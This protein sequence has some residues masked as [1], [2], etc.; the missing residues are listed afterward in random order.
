M[1]DADRPITSSSQDRLGRA[2]FA[3]Y[4]ARC[5]LDHK[6]P[7]SMVVGL[8]GGW[9]SGKTSVINLIVEELKRAASAM[10]EEDQPI[11]LNFSP[12]SYSGQHQLI[13]S[14]FRRLSAVIR[15]SSNLKNKERIITLLELYVSYFSEKPLP[16]IMLPKRHWWQHKQPKPITGWES[17][18]DL[19]Q[20]KAELNHLLG[21]E[22]CRIVIIIDNITRLYDDEIKLMFQIV[23][24]MGDYANTTY[25]LALDKDYVITAINNVDG[26]GGEELLEKVVQLPFTITPI[27]QQDVEPILADRLKNVVLQVPEDTWNNEYWADLYYSSL[28]YFFKNCRDIT[29]YV[30]TLNFSY[31]RVKDIVNPVDYF[32][33]TAIEI[34]LPEIYAGIR[35]NKDLFTDL[36]DDVYPLTKT[37]MPVEKLRVHEILNREPAIP[38]D[39]ILALLLKL[40]PRLRHICQPN[41]K[42]Y[43]STAI[44]R[45]LK[46]ICCPDLFDVYFRLS[47]QSGNIPENEFNTI[48]TLSAGEFDQALMRLNQDNR[49]LKFLDLL[50]QNTLKIPQERLP[51]IINALVDNGDL[52]PV[53]A[54]AGP[55][56]LDTPM[57]LHRIIHQCLRRFP[58]KERFGI[59]SHAVRHAVKSIYISVRELR[60]QTREHLESEDTFVPVEYR[61]FTPD[62][63]DKLKHE[64]VARIAFW[65]EHNDLGA[66]PYL[67]PVLYAW[68]DWGKDNVCHDYVV[69]LTST[70]K[71]LVAFL[72]AILQEAITEAMT[73]YQKDPS[74]DQYLKN[75]KDFIDPE[76]LK[77]HA[78][79][80]F[81]D[82]YF[83]K[84]R[85]REQLALMIFLDLMK[86]DVIKTIPRTSA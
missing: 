58:Q 73:F 42:T 43:H 11:I 83:E 76:S 82:Q 7:D 39:I 47:L 50:D 44:A 51:N 64:C 79:L 3:Q 81:T 74:W 75:I 37:D 17:G 1:Y 49:I 57:R 25:L 63:L 24:S 60:E 80:L 56:S 35:D 45:R 2:Q 30:N 8:Y 23:K 46:R 72:C 77:E 36:M 19:T 84:F 40:F 32:A 33:L 59:L 10:L 52:F 15:E 67:L 68:H 4:L 61:D 34:F 65:S 48:L 12:W 29:R 69:K 55:L 9:G 14:F 38:A 54:G 41:V 78:Q 20:V 85:E 5:L 21:Q 66:Y 31:S 6:D 28:K 62:E 16:E 22:K 13:Y 27:T 53:G 70:D 18:R 71:G 86:S 26:T